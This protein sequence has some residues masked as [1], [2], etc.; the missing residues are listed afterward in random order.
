MKQTLVVIL[1]VFTLTNSSGQDLDR[2]ATSFADRMCLCIGDI[3]LYD[4][5]EIKLGECYDTAVMAILTERI[6]E[7][8][9]ILTNRE[10]FEYVKSNSER[11]VK[12]RCE[13]IRTLIEKEVRP[14]E[15][16]IAFPLN[17]G[18]KELKKAKRKKEL[19]SGRIIAFE[20]E[21]IE[22]RTPAPNKPYLKVQLADGQ[23][24]W[25]GSMANSRF[26]KAGS[27]LK[28]LGYFS[29]TSPD[30]ISK[31]YHDMGFHVFAFAEV[32]KSSNE[33]AMF[34]GSDAQVKQW[35]EGKIPTGK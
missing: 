4:S 23:I 20:G 21:I 3:S 31:K 34:A 30:D 25:V 1:T 33:V 17:F 22:V 9:E 15:L 5:L 6:P 2:F 8:V 35:A 12:T 14:S 10:Q 11:L 28:F 27:Q 26:D 13:A 16:A 19:W 7:E 29:L 32:E 24:I 18:T